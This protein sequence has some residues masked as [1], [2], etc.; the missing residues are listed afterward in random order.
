MFSSRRAA[1]W[2]VLEEAATDADQTDD[3][4]LELSRI[5]MPCMSV[6]CFAA[7]LSAPRAAFAFGG[8]ITFLLGRKPTWITPGIKVLPIGIKVP[9]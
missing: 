2:L 8:S 7:H 1:L 9:L 6:V 4:V 5:I 3:G